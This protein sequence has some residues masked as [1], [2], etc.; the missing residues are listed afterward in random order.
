MQAIIN[1]VLSSNK[2]AAHAAV[3][4]MGI[5]ICVGS[6][7]VQVCKSITT[8]LLVKFQEGAISW[9]EIYNPSGPC[10]TIFVNVN[11]GVGKPDIHVF[12]VPFEEKH[13]KRPN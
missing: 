1:T 10:V 3:S 12:L 2:K 11:H 8:P 9:Q 6:N 5:R 7:T 13:D 4:A